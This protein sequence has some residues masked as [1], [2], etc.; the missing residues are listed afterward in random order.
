[1]RLALTNL[2]LLATLFAGLS[3]C[4]ALGIDDSS[5]VNVFVAHA[6]T[7]EGDAPPD[8]GQAE[9]PREFDNDEGW[10]IVLGEA[11]VTVS[12]VRLVGCNGNEQ[13]VD[14]Y[15]G[16]CAEDF[17]NTDDA[18]ALGI[19]GIV[20]APGAYCEAIVTYGRFTIDEDSN[21]ALPGND[22]MENNSVLLRGYAEKNGEFVDFSFVTDEEFVAVVDLTRIDD[23]SAFRVAPQSPLPKDLTI[24]KP[25]NHFFDGVDFDNYDEDAV[26]DAVEDSL[27]NFTL[28]VVGQDVMKG[29]EMVP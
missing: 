23:G 18:V 24:V 26:Q 17:I 7:P 21:H 5:L 1:M 14:L 8:L 9:Y 3:G 28:A 2:T 6:P 12:G 22:D 27:E 16:A 29:L 19:G 4:D 10:S 15:W 20:T 11:Y 25:Y 13:A